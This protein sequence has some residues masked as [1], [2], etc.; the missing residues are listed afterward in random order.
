MIY[1]KPLHR[2]LLGLAYSEKGANA[3]DAYRHAAALVKEAPEAPAIH[4][5]TYAHVRWERDMAMAQLED[6]GAGFTEKM[7]DFSRVVRCK[8]CRFYHSG[9][10]LHYCRQNLRRVEET[11]FC[12][13]GE[14][15]D[16]G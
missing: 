15:R 6:I 12:S 11:D 13:Y 9:E 10:E 2:L 7:D 8:D 14:R 16:N 1:R 3:A 5:V 4:P